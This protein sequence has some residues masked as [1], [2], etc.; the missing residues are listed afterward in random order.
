M[1]ACARCDN[2]RWVCENYTDRPWLGGACLRLLR[3]SAL[4]YLQ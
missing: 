4:P 3:R 1:Q 2:C